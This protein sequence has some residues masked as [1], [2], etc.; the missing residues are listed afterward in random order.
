MTQLVCK[1]ENTY[2][3]NPITKYVCAT[4]RNT[5]PPKRN[6]NGS[7]FVDKDEYKGRL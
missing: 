5:C 3:I 7:L 6:V 1:T 4:P 2:T